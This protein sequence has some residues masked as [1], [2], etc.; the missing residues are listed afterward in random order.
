MR[1]A[2][3]RLSTS[4]IQVTGGIANWLLTDPQCRIQKTDTIVQIVE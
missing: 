4:K 1:R 3:L 2:V